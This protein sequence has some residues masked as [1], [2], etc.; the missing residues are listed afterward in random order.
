[1]KKLLSILMAVVMVCSLCVIPASAASP[2][3]NKSTA[4]LPIGYSVTLKVSNADKVTW[5]S[6]DESVAKI[7]SS[8]GNT[9]KIVGVGSGTTH[10]IAKVGK[11]NLKC[12]I[13]VKKSFITA[14][15]EKVSVGIGKTITA[16]VSVKGSKKISYSNG[17]PEKCTI[18]SVKWDGDKLKFK[19]KGKAAGS[20]LIKVYAK[21]YSKTTM[22]TITV[23]VTGKNTSSTS[24]S[25]SSTS[26]VS[27]EVKVVDLVNEEREAAGLPKLVMDDSL[28]KVAKLR[29]E[30]L[31]NNL[32]HTRPNGTNCFTAL[33]ENGIT[34][35]HAA[36]NIAAGQRDAEEVM[37]TWMRSTGHRDN[38]LSADAEK[39]GV[40]LVETTFGYGYYWVQ[41]FTD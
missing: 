28:N 39:I 1:M 3:L 26:S 33:S 32:S 5:S 9:A 25:A 41:V 29:A 23:N 20:A 6:R 7:K 35:G 40:A 30:E 16:T 11:K 37:S 4:S 17:A 24:S 18:T 14:E 21:G 34:Y 12:K 36:E 19:I 2:K 38:I 8:K 15:K 10:I 22:E 31:L 13:T 27:E